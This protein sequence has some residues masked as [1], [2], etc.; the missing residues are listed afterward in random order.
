M[1]QI[2]QM[3]PRNFAITRLKEKRDALLDAPRFSFYMYNEL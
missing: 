3:K 1:A 2:N